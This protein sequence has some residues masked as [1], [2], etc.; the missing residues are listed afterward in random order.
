MTVPGS[1]IDS[2]FTGLP[3]AST[4]YPHV[5]LSYVRVFSL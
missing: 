4:L 1:A 3:F 2:A 5:V